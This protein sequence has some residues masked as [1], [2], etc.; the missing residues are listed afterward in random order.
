MRTQLSR[1]SANAST[2]FVTTL[3]KKLAIMALAA[4]A[5]A[6][7][8]AAAQDIG[9]AARFHP[10]STGTPF[11]P[12]I[13]PVGALKSQRV[14][15]VVQM[16]AEPVAAARAVAPDHKIGQAQHEGIAA[17]I[18]Q[19]HADIEPEITGRVLRLGYRI[20]EVPITYYA[21]GRGEGKKLTWRDG[22]IALLTLV[23]IRLT[24]RSW[25][26]GEDTRYHA[27][28]LR[29]L[30]ATTRFPDLPLEQAS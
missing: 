28:R 14:T 15:V 22:V 20:H 26:F 12:A 10:F 18:A 8:V 27:A 17:V 3:S 13:V 21:R 19:Q 6:P 16:S 24:P 9:G 2:P 29:A 30:A 23:R 4:A 5:V 7:I 1:A 11:T 25:L